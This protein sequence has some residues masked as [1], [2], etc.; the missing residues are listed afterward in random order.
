MVWKEKCRWDRDALFNTPKVCPE[1]ARLYTESYK[2]TEGL[3]TE[4]RIAKAFA[5]TL[6]NMTIFIEPNHLLVGNLASSPVASPVWPEYGV[7]WLE[8][9][10]DH[11]S[12][13]PHD[14]FLIDDEAKR[15]IKE[16]V[17]Y[18]KDKGREEVIV[19]RTREILPDNVKK[20]FDSESYGIRPVLYAGYNKASGGAGHTPLNYEKALKIGLMGLIKEAEKSLAAINFSER[21]AVDRV[22]FLRS[23]IISLKAAISFAKRYADL[24][25]K[26]AEKETDEKRKWELIEISRICNWVPKNPARSFWEA[27]QATWFIHLLRWLESN[28]HSVTIGRMDQFLYPYFEKDVRE[29]TITREQARELVENLFIKMAEVKRLRHWIETTFKSGYPLFQGITIGGQT[30]EGDC[31]VNELSYLILEVTGRLKLPE[32]VVT[33][34][35]YSRIPDE[36]LVKC[37]ETLVKHGGGLPSFF[38]DGAIISA[39][40]NEGIPLIEARNYS[41]IPCSEAGV[42]GRHIDHTGGDCYINLLKVLE[43]ALNG[44]TDPESGLC[45]CPGEKD[46]STF[47]SFNEIWEAYEK[48]LGYYV[49][50][51]PLFTAISSQLYAELNPTPFTSALMDH[52]IEI[53]KDMARGGGPTKDICDEQQGHGVANVANALAAIKRLVFDDQKLN[54]QE[55]NEALMKNFEGKRCEEIRRLLLKAPKYGNDDDYVDLLAVN[56]AKHFNEEIKKCGTTWRGGTYGV[57]FQSLTANVPEGKAT[58]ATP[59]GRKRGEALADNISPVAGTDVNGVTAML[60]S[61]AKIDNSLYRYGSILNVRF[62]P[63]ALRG[64]GINKLAALII[65]YLVDYKGWQIQ[66][67]IISS[68]TLRDAQQHPEKYKDLVVKVAGYCA[69]FIALDKRLQEQIILRTENML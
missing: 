5:K 17:C 38:G 53:G 63:T 55:L 46:L 47:H 27:L 33:C 32:P 22:I 40:Q 67:N 58:G 50:F 14:K 44:G 8:K 61:V 21:D 60:R 20:A 25:E 51:I 49:R 41:V 43:L 28:G 26:L 19:N 15:Q 6:A 11:L 39:M 10:L 24:A 18:W 69:Q 42:A 36:F 64:E 37:V 54:L 48:Q 13:R 52:R 1:R 68:D 65:T 66:F 29:G 9:E 59:D 56:V 12:E 16:L 7:T 45:L 30:S 31:A 35:V 57:S 4:I 3:Q 2:E 34:R 23:V 62:H